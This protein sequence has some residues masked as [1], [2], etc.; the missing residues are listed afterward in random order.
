[1]ISCC[2]TNSTPIVIRIKWICSRCS[3]NKNN[4]TPT[5]FTEE[6]IRTNASSW[7]TKCRI[8]CWNSTSETC[9]T[10]TIIKLIWWRIKS[11][12][13]YIKFNSSN[14]TNICIYFSDI[15]WYTRSISMTSYISLSIM[16]IS[17]LIDTI[18]VITNISI[19]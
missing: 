16:I 10:T 6:I 1:M 19:I 9:S 4:L 14:S 11:N 17:N 15:C 2:N 3:I 12:S 13:G 8:I 18:N 7:S 5:K